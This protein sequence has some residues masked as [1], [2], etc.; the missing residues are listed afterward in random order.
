MQRSKTAAGAAFGKFHINSLQRYLEAIEAIKPCWDPESFVR[1]GPTLTTFF[2][3]EERE[4]PNT[5]IIRP[6]SA[7]ERN[8][9]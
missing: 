6:S 4:D 2:L 5:T 1:R 9:I 7:R 8:A 3:V